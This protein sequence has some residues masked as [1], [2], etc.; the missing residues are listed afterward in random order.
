[1][2]QRRPGEPMTGGR[3]SYPLRLPRYLPGEVRSSSSGPAVQPPAVG[4][5]LQGIHTPPTTPHPAHSTYHGYPQAGWEPRATRTSTRSPL[6]TPAFRIHPLLQALSSPRF[7]AHRQPPP[8]SLFPSPPNEAC[9]LNPFVL[10]FCLVSSLPL[11]TSRKLG[12]CSSQTQSRRP[13]STGQPGGPTHPPSTPHRPRAASSTAA[14]RRGARFGSSQY[15][16]VIPATGPPASSRL[17]TLSSYACCRCRCYVSCHRVVV[18][19][20][21]IWPGPRPRSRPPSPSLRHPTRE[22][23]LSILPLRRSVAL[24]HAAR[25]VIDNVN[26]QI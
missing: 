14:S 22:I 17:F 26:V 7:S 19:L 16:L 2:F 18:A 4:P 11:G 23:I 13:T 24:C 3:C 15:P 10:C 20:H 6:S 9:I 8:P 1:M 12:G 21:D 25:Q 5:R